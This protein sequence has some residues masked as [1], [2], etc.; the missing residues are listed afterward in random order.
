MNCKQNEGIG[1]L[2]LNP[3]E[4]LLP[5]LAFPLELLQF[6]EF[7]TGFYI[8]PFLGEQEMES[9]LFCV[10]CIL[11]SICVQCVRVSFFSDL[12]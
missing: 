2:L 7:S 11:S 3:F 9:E 10:A 12:G 1:L 5:E 6:G 4:P 8:L